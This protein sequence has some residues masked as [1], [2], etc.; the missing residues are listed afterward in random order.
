MQEEGIIVAKHTKS[1][2]ILV[3]LLMKYSNSGMKIIK[4]LPLQMY[5]EAFQVNADSKAK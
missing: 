2:F 4:L 3:L 5:K 1:C